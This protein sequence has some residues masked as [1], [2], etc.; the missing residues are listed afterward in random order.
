MN[1]ALPLVISVLTL[2]A[3]A[4]T[5][6]AKG[7]RI[8]KETDARDVGFGD[9]TAD[10]MMT[11]K[12]RAGQTSTRKLHSKVLEGKGDGDK[13]LSLFNTPADVKGTSMLTFSHGLKADDQW[14][15]LPALKR[16][17]R[18]NS[19]NKSGPFMGSE[20]AFEDL[21]SQEV[22]KYK[23]KYLREEACGKGW[24]CHV[25]ERIPA[26]KYSGYSKQIG[27]TDTK[28]HR[29]VKIEFY[30]RKGSKMKTL[31]SSGYKQYL[32]KYWRPSVMSMQNHLTGK[33]TV[34]QWTNYKLGTGLS[35]R[36]FNKNAL[37]R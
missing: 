4:E 22:E 5:P 15:Y 12:N 11:L 18:I 33:S 24:K 27:W 6:E 10:M 21:G 28:E 26:Y 30:D 3:M 35:K 7:L 9:S 31:V 32:G 13:S 2:N 19:R 37:K 1:V 17:K 8:A 25:V 29:A 16:V 14:L 20:F 34:L 23:Y 36:D